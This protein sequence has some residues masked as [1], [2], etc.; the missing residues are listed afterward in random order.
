[1]SLNV[2]TLRVI[3]GDLP[4]LNCKMEESARKKY[5]NASF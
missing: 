5:V 4:G 2:W 1:M 3:S